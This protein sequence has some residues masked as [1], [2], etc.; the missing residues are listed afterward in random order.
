MLLRRI[1]CAWALS[2]ALYPIHFKDTVKSNF[3]TRGNAHR[4]EQY[5]CEYG[6]M[7]DYFN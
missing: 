3:R 4:C 2:L 5:L 1:E 6:A 7:H